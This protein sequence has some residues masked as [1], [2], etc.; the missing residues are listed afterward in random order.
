VHFWSLFDPYFFATFYR[1]EKQPKTTFFGTFWHI[2]FFGKKIA[3]PSCG[4]GC[5]ISVPRGG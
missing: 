4:G 5:P 1:F 3:P 2:S